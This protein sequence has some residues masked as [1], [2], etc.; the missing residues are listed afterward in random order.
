MIPE[1]G[2]DTPIEQ[3]L[4]WWANTSC[5]TGLSSETI[6][7]VLGHLTW[8]ELQNKP[9]AFGVSSSG[10]TPKDGDDFGRC[11]RLLELIPEWKSELHQVAEAYANT[12]WPKLIQNWMR[13]SKL[14]NDKRYN[15]LYFA[16]K[17]LGA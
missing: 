10:W 16:L 15:E 9:G 13:L 1:P 14:F 2:K 12:A 3:R 6:A 8:E 7:L 17:E 4:E 5:D 11:H